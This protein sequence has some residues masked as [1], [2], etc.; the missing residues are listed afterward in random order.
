LASGIKQST[1]FFNHADH[2]P[3]ANL[4]FHP[5]LPHFFLIDAIQVYQEV[6]QEQL[7][8]KAH[9]YLAWFLHKYRNI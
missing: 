4:E 3:K 6:I 8:P 7:F 9:L 1:E 2:D 5:E